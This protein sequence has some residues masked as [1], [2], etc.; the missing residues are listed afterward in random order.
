[1]SRVID[2]KRC[3]P[4]TVSQNTQLSR[5]FTRQTSDWIEWKK[6]QQWADT[7]GRWGEVMTLV[8][9]HSRFI[10]NAQ[11][12]HFFLV[13]V[14]SPLLVSLPCLQIPQANSFVQF[15]S[16]VE[17]LVKDHPEESPPLFYDPFFWNWVGA[18]SPVHRRF[19]HGGGFYLTC[20]DFWENVRQFIPRCA[21]FF[22]FF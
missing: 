13:D 1:M 17:P 8:L 19:L 4:L 2:S 21:F 5:S 12:R 7:H 18:L 10:I 6:Q 11:R 14:T 16:T 15:I 9:W 22:F 3:C 20:E